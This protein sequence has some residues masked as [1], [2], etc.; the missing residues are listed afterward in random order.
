MASE[1]GARI[2]DA[3]TFWII[4]CGMTALAIVIVAVPILRARTTASPTNLAIAVYA[5][6]LAEVDRDRERGLIGETEAGAARIE[7]SRRILRADQT[8]GSAPVQAGPRRA[9]LVA[10]LIAIV[11]AG[12]S[13]TLYARLGSPRMGDEPLAERKAVP[14][15][16]LSTDALVARLDD[17]LA[18]HPDDVRGWDVAAPVYLRLGRIDDAVAAF[19]NAIRLGGANPQRQSGLGEALTAAANGV[20]T[21]EARQAFAAANA[22]DP[23]FP[24]PKMYLALALSQDGKLKEAADAWRKLIATGRGYEPWVQVAKRE[25]AG[26]EAKLSKSDATAPAA[27]STT[28][29]AGPTESALPAQPSPSVT[30][31]A[32]A[33]PTAAEPPAASA[34]NA[35]IET[36]VAGLASRL[37]QSGGTPEEWGRLLKSYLVL[38]R[39]DDAKS[40]YQKA[41]AAFAAKPDELARLTSIA[42]DLGLDP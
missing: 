12:V 39:A 14:T 35:M 4:L 28:L 7:I 6:Q 19:R 30:S 27:P 18:K 26:I 25:L 33:P 3:M 36:M 31:P 16:Q 17:A 34:Q 38:G 8:A 20:V 42:T 9:Y 29:P 2:A 1:W 22:A 5:Q 37:D 32:S 11:I 23:N 40:T 13:V 24:T 15:E 41:R 21:S 10:G